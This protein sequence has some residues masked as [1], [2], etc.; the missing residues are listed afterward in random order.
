MMPSWLR[1]LT[2]NRRSRNDSIVIVSGLPRSGTSMLMGMLSAGG[3]ELLTDGLRTADQ[4]NPKGYYEFE[5]V[6]KLNTTTDRAWLGGARGKGL[7]VISYLLPYLPE[8]YDYKIIFVR[9]DLGEVLASQKKMLERR[10][11]PQGETNDEDLARMFAGHLRKIEA[12]IERR[13]NCKVLYVDHR[14]TLRAP[15]EVARQISRF[16][17]RPLDVDRM[18][19]AVDE[20]LYRNRRSQP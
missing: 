18:A 4:D 9:R 3:L 11:E 19:H 7:K 5:P 20:E 6:K 8:T 12:E 1:L 15:A 17:G 16:L 13:S 10:G 2:G 14:E